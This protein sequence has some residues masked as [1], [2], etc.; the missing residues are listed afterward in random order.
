MTFTPGFDQQNHHILEL[1]CE[2]EKY[3][4]HRTWQ[5]EGD[6]LF[7]EQIAGYYLGHQR[8]T[9][10]DLF[11]VLKIKRN[12]CRNDDVTNNESPV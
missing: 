12:L 10:L 7:P 4:F 2:T 6:Q 1:I 9:F 5:A 11:V 8:L 3:F